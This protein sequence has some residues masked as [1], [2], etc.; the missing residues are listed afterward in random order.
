MLGYDAISENP[1]SALS[2]S[3]PTIISPSETV[4]VFDNATVLIPRQTKAF[5]DRESIS[6]AIALQLFIPLRTIAPTDAQA[7]SDAA[8]LEHLMREIRATDVQGLRDAVLLQHLTDQ[9]R[10]FDSVPIW[11]DVA[12]QLFVAGLRGAMAG[13]RT[14]TC[15]PGFEMQREAI[16]KTNVADFDI[17]GQFASYNVG[18]QVPYK[19]VLNIPAL[20]RVQQESLSAFH[21]FHKGAK[22][23]YFDG[24]YAW[25]HISTLSL[26]AEADG[27]RKD[28]YLPNRNID[29]N[30]IT[31]AVFNGATHSITTAYSLNATPGIISFT[32]APSSGHDIEASHGHKYKCMFEPDGFKIDEFAVGV[33]RCQIKLRELL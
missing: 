20:T 5:S 24:A 2:N 14:F 30:S 12:L 27:A 9:M 7:T 6:D 13:I 26:V 32:T 23:F 21:F 17:P 3:G 29:T 4:V 33:W 18:D 22:A 15:T 11:D 1:I 28:F 8:F 25:S 10:F 31:V 19:F 16:T